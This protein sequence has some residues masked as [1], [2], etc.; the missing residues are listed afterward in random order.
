MPNRVSNLVVA[1][2]LSAAFVF[3]PTAAFG[4]LPPN[5][6]L[7]LHKD[8]TQLYGFGDAFKNAFSNDD[9]LGK[10]KDA[11]LSNI[12]LTGTRQDDNGLR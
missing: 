4:V 10:A 3:E 6:R 11:G 5:R 8:T 9:S 1:T 7:G 2:A 12:Y